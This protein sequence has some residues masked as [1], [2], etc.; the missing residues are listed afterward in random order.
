MPIKTNEQDRYTLFQSRNW[1]CFTRSLTEVRLSRY[2]MTLVEFYVVE[3]IVGTDQDSSS[4]QTSEQDSDTLF[5]AR[6]WTCFTRSLTKVRLS[7]YG[8][9]LEESLLFLGEVRPIETTVSQLSRYQA[10]QWID[11]LKRPRN[12]SPL[13]YHWPCWWLAGVG[14]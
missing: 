10:V 9:V 12:C 13:H 11:W 1:T 3:M 4:V 5:Q 7:R 8:M 14:D 6:N 2:G